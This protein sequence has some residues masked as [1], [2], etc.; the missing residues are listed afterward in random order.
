MIKK[1][2]LG[3]FVFLSI[4]NF[5]I[6]NSEIFI[7]A[8]VNNQVITNFDVQNENNYLLALNPGLRNLPNENIDR[9]AIFINMFLMTEDLCWCSVPFAN[10]LIAFSI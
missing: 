1:I 9:Y 4:I 2:F 3:I 8:K 6:V 10:R 5:K 7:K